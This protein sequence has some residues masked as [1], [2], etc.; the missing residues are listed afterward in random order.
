MIAGLR[1]QNKIKAG[2]RLQRAETSLPNLGMISGKEVLS[3]L[4]KAKN[5]KTPPKS[6][7]RRDLGVLELHY[8]IWN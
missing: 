5:E 7:A 2:V 8:P 4:H 1:I 3:R 6:A